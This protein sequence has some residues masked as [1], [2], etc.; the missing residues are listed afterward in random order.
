MFKLLRIEIL[1]F[2]E[3]SLGTLESG[4]DGILVDFLFTDRVFSQN[5]DAIP[6][7][8]G[9]PAAHNNPLSLTVLGDPQLSM[10]HLSQERDVAGQDTDFAF[11]RGNDDR[12]NRVRID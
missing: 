9:K 3:S 2:L 7:D 8:L 10:L 11:D 5:A 12:I 6:F 1:G 4:F